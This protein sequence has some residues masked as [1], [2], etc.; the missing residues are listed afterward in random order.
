MNR[1]HL[2]CAA[3]L[4]TSI[5][6]PQAVSAQAQP[7]P[8][9]AAHKLEF[10]VVSIR[11]S[12]RK[13]VSLGWDFLNPTGKMMPPQGGV[14]SWNAPLLNL[15][16]F[17]YDLRQPQVSRG[18]AMSLPKWAQENWY[19]IEA[20]AA[21]NPTRDDVRQMVRSM[22]EERFH[23]AAHVEKREGDVFSLVVEKP[24]L[25]LKPHTEGEPC[26]LPPSVADSKKYPHAYPSYDNWIFRC[27]IMNREL[28]HSGE[29]RLEMLDVPMD[30]IVSTLSSATIMFDGTG[31]P[32][33]DNTGLQGH[34]DAVLDYG[35]PVPRDAADADDATGAPQFP[36]A[37]EKQL[38]LKLVKQKAQVDV[39]IID[40]VEQPTEN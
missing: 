30:Q 2:L 37:L 26:K 5:A 22:L 38:G 6:I 23:F 33:A 34:Y 25:G 12:Q 29:R 19:A 15:I 18:A 24:G 16:N 11:P 35:P 27:G 8:A 1:I 4:S 7:A 9:A 10:D 14:F 40:H 28:S 17:A 13:F 31:L 3:I 32:I 36:I 21:G 39:F 20:R